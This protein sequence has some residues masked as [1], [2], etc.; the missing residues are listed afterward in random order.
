MTLLKKYKEIVF[1]GKDNIFLAV[2]MIF[3]KNKGGLPLEK[4]TLK[5]DISWSFK[6]DL[7][8]LRFLL[9]RMIK[10]TEERHEGYTR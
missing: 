3:H 9:E 2:D 5:D 1:I 4:N 6:R 7:K 8:I 10:S